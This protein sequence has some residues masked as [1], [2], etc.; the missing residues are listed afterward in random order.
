[1]LSGSKI[2]A[3]RPWRE[4]AGPG[5]AQAE[6]QRQ[7]QERDLDGRR[8]RIRRGGY[9]SRK[10]A[11][12]VLARLRTPKADGTG[13]MVT[14][15]D[16]LAHWLVSSTSPAAS[17][18]RGYAAH[19]RLYLGPYLGEVLLTKLTVGQV[20]A[21]FTA[22]IRQHQALGTPVSAAVLTRIRATLRAALN[23]A[24]RRGLIRDNPAACAELPRAR[25]PRAVVWTPYR[26][27][28]WRRSGE[29]PPVVVWTA[30][31]TAQFLDLVR[32]H[33][34]VRRLPPDRAAR[35]AAR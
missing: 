20:Q 1:V 5:R 21:M 18:V 34:T 6:R 23:A 16:W 35:P 30:R 9:P 10:A 33:R 27:G 13:G 7:G 31:Q 29:R 4:L 22:I 11:L 17:T 3:G 24:I 25:C 26:V 32:W 19:V 28:Q 2:L 12:D 14:V 15:G 8:R